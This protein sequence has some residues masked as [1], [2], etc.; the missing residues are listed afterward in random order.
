MT[1]E[2]QD[3]TV[4]AVLLTCQLLLSI[5]CLVNLSVIITYVLGAEVS[6]YLLPVSVIAAIGLNFLFARQLGANK[7][8]LFIATVAS[9]FLLTVSLVISSS[10]FDFSWD[11][12]WYHQAAVYDLAGGW[13]PVHNP[14]VTPDGNN[15]LSILHFP[16]SA[17]FFSAAVLRLFGTVEMGKAYNIMALF[18]A[19][20]VVYVLIRD[21][22]V[23]T[24]K[25]LILT[26]LV[27]LNPVVWSELTSY[28]NDGNLY[29]FMVIYLA[30][31]IAWLRNS[32]PLFITI[33]VMAVSC[34]VNTKFTGLIFFLISSFFI[35]VYILIRERRR[36]RSFLLI[37]ITAG[38]VAVLI[39]GFNPYVTNMLNRGNP[40]Y[41][42]LG[43][44]DHPSVFA[45]GS[46]DNEAYETPHNMQGK[47]LPARL[48]YANF[49][50]P[51][52][53]PYNN[54]ENAQPGFSFFNA[55][56]LWRAYEYHETRVAGF[57]PYFGILLMIALIVLPVLL[58]NVKKIRV[59]TIIFFAGLCCCLALSKH[60]WW[61]RFFPM[62]WLVP[63]LLMFFLW[64]VPEYGL[65]KD[66]ING[67]LKAIN[68][69]GW[70]FALIIGINGFI[71]AFIHVRWETTSS[72][73]LKTELQNIQN[74]K[75]P[76]EVDYGWFKRS[77]EEKLTRLHIKY[78]PVTL[79]ATDTGVQKLTSVT[80]GYPN[81]VLYRL[82]KVP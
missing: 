57:G 15:H 67:R 58:F 6:A 32:K 77:M 74:K 11:G 21:F 47:S 82:K 14:L 49:S 53:A 40:L 26:V 8:L 45:N 72:V 16:K 20:G 43:S 28:L 59:P 63:I 48:M 50:R 24:F 51:G 33:A 70:L 62:L 31:V 38:I 19:F 46:D 55:D 81:Q 35:L 78:T 17:W 34:L 61:P 69:F 75:L 66:K 73:N 13:N 36:V 23:K 44:K 68:T 76:V 54:E 1:I 25:S 3:R 7:R 18:A 64:A 2:N 9:L 60:F 41:P 65:M 79:K 80:E 30:S 27:V 37:H 12:Q 52:N 5:I 56:N 29:L 39:F 10:Y 71:V 42:L 22:K 4:S